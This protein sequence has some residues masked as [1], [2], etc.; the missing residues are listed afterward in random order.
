ME[1]L[2]TVHHLVVPPKLHHNS[3]LNLKR[4]FFRIHFST[5]WSPVGH[6]RPPPYRSRP[7]HTNC[8]ASIAF[9]SRHYAWFVSCCGPRSSAAASSDTPHRGEPRKEAW[10]EVEFRL[11]YII[12]TRSRRQD[13]AHSASRVATWHS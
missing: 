2:V 13:A 10:S 12:S 4:R 7:L 3:R 8:S 1:G 5:D 11:L 6:R 9:P